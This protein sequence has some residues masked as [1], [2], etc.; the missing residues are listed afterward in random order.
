M[1]AVVDVVAF[2]VTLVAFVAAAGH[3]GYL[4][5]L[6]SAA[7]KRPGGQP[8]VDFAR[9]RMPVTGVTLGVTLLALLISSGGVG[10][11]IVAI[12]LGGGGGIASV[13]ALQSSQTRFRSGRY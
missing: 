11:D 3:G 9:K 8:A 7:R 2:I 13:K 12:L 6:S 4:A 1:G 10:A 5:M